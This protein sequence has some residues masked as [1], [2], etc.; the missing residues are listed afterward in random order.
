MRPSPAPDLR[1][2]Q[3]ANQAQRECR[4]D[5]ALRLYRDLLYKHPVLR[6]LVAAEI[7]R[8][9][10]QLHL[11]RKGLAGVSL[12][13]APAAPSAPPHQ[14]FCSESLS[15]YLQL[16]PRA[17]DLPQAPQPLPLVSIVM[18]AYNAEDTVQ[19]AVES[20]LNQDWPNLEVL[21]CDDGSSD[22]TWDIL[23][24]MAR[25]CKPLRV[26]RLNGNYGTYLAKNTAARHAVGEFVLF[27]D[28]DDISHP[29]RAR[30]QVLPLL[31]NDK[32]VATRT[33]YL[34]YREDTGAIIPVAGLASKYGLI[35]GAGRRRG[36]R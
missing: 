18:T 27:Q 15:A 8:S 28:S 29:A 5:D 34:R 24:A 23:N 17:G 1:L 14:A 32:L 21:V 16:H 13:A 33:K 3:R 22:G 2:L 10:R 25:R 4:H 6:D 12:A 35:T 11:R 31:A 9:S 30:M 20:M 36:F 19:E 7:D 26:M